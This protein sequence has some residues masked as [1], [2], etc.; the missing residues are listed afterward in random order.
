MVEHDV[1][2]S[3]SGLGEDRIRRAPVW[4]AAINAV[5]AFG[6][7]LPI[8]MVAAVAFS[9]VDPETMGGLTFSAGKDLAIVV[10]VFSWIWLKGQRV[11]A[12]VVLAAVV[13]GV[14]FL[15]VAAVGEKRIGREDFAK[16]AAGDP[17]VVQ[18]GDFSE[19]VHEGLGISMVVPGAKL[20][21]V[22][23]KSPDFRTRMWAYQDEL[24]GSVFS[25][26]A[27]HQELESPDE[28]SRFMDGVLSGFQSEATEHNLG[29]DIVSRSVSRELMTAIAE[30]SLGE[31]AVVYK[32][33][34]VSDPVSGLHAAV[35]GQA[36]CSQG[37]QGIQVVNSL[38]ASSPSTWHK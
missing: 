8:G 4:Q 20:S 19:I 30:G 28:L 10:F 5:V 16:A 11:L 32:V 25:I 1:E 9:K 3:N 36:V 2:L 38:Q 24:S 33:I 7:S 29:F 13:G 14:G 34:Y 23:A 17:I 21:R 22:G 15:A 18:T 6:V 37:D 27:V 35:I 26:G 12:V 31:A